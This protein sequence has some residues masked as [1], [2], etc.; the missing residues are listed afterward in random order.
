VGVDFIL[1]AQVPGEGAPG[2]VVVL[3]AFAQEAS[4]QVEVEAAPVREC[5]VEAVVVAQDAQ[6]NKEI[7]YE[8]LY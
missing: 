6:I 7:G 1:P 3:E 5:E 2:A 4:H 8:T